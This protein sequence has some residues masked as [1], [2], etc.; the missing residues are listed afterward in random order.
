MLHEKRVIVVM[1]A[2]NAERTLRKTYGEIPK[3]VVDEVILVDDQSQDSTTEI[4]RSLGIKTI[5]HSKNLGYGGN[6]KTCY[7]EALRLG[8]DIVVMVHPDYQYTPKLIMAMA[9]MITVG[10]L[11]IPPSVSVT[12][13]SAK[14]WV[15]R[16]SDRISL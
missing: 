5:V 9:S 3:D 10:R 7:R 8:A 2:Y 15:P 4:A 14:R 6:Q 16:S 13:G 11:S 12:Q 1:P